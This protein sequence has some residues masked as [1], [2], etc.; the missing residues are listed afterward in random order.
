MAISKFFFPTVFFLSINFA[1]G[2]VTLGLTLTTTDGNARWP[3]SSGHFAFGFRQIY[4][5]NTFMLAV[6]YD[7]IPDKTIVWNAN[8]DKP[9]PTGSK[10]QLTENGLTL[11]DPQGESIWTT[12]P[13]QSVSYG[14]MLDTGNFVLASSYSTL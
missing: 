1:S 5:T 2:N 6:W 12:E 9:V 7:K 4:N 8:A 11:S 14:V 10:V 3:S 13:S